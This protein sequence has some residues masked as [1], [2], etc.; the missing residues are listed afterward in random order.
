MLCENCH[1]PEN[2]HRKQWHGDVDCINGEIRCWD[3]PCQ[4]VFSPVWVAAD[5]GPRPFFISEYPMLTEKQAFEALDAA[6]A[7][8]DHGRGEWPTLSVAE[9][10]D[11]LEQFV[12]RMIKV[13]DPVVQFLMWE[14]GKSLGDSTKEFDRT[15]QYIKETI[16]ALKELD[17]VLS[18]FTIEVEIMPQIRRAPL[19]VVLCMGPFNYSLNETFTTLIPALVMGNTVILKPPKQGALLY[20]PLLDAFCEVFPK[21]VINVIYGEGRKMIPL[22]MASGKINVLGLIGTSKTANAFKKKHPHPN[23]LRCV[24]GL[25]AK[26]PAI[27]LKGADHDLAVKECILGSLSFNG[28]RCTAL[29]KDAGFFHSNP[30]GCQTGDKSSGSRLFF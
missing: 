20:A 18:R 2:I 8:Y 5:A 15:I 16:A 27:V 24:L 23:R 25:E 30:G 29:S 7:A 28:Q 11:Y 4:E 3:G 9:R 21:R 14:V 13:K 26:N 17:R 12:F 6:V 22:L 1:H 19:G 10:I